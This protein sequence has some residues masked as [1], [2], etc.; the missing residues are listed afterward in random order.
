MRRTC[1]FR[2]SRRVILRML[3]AADPSVRSYAA[4]MAGYLKLGQFDGELRGMLKSR[5]PAE[6]HAAATALDMLGVDRTP[7]AKPPGGKG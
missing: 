6:T 5:H 1:R 3:R 4:T 7:Q 2:P